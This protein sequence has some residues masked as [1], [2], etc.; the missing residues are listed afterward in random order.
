MSDIYSS[1]PR[2]GRRAT[3]SSEVM[4]NGKASVTQKVAM[5]TMT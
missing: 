5:I 1:I 3:G 2:R 4:A